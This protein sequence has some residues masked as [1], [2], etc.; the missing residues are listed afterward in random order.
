MTKTTIR[1]PG[2]SGRVVEVVELVFDDAMCCPK[3]AAPGS[4][5]ML[6]R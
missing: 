2:S 6:R 1:S 4:A 5:L 3:V